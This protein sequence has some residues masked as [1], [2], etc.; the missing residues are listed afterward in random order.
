MYCAN[1]KNSSILLTRESAWP[2]QTPTG[3][4]VRL[5]GT[6]YVFVDTFVHPLLK[7]VLESL[8]VNFKQIKTHTLSLED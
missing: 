2:W 4:A 6:M 7:K 1:R 5:S 3:N 8:W